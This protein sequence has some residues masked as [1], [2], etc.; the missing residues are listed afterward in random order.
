MNIFSKRETLTQNITYMAI[1]A[2]I[3]II[4]S[5]IAAFL[6]ILSLF[7]MIILPLTSTLVTL[8]CKN[9]YYLIYAVATI[10]LSLVATLYNMGN[11]ILYLVPSILTGFCFGM[12]AKY[13]I[14]SVWYI[15][16]TSIVQC[17][18]T[19]A[20]IPLINFIFSSDIIL[21]FKTALNL[22]ESQ[23]ID[24]IVPTA[25]LF[26]SMIQMLFTYI[27]ISLEMQKFD[28][29]FT[30][31]KIITFADSICSLVAIILMIICSF[32]YIPLSYIFLAVSIYFSAFCF[33]GLIIKHYKV[34]L[35][36]IPVSLLP[37]II[38][39]ALLY[40]LLPNQTG[41][42]LISVFPFFIAL[43]TFINS[44]LKKELS[45]DKLIDK[46]NN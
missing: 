5:V 30:S 29:G 43:I 18:C 38:I 8:Y 11:T 26:L 6:P 46:E 34:A 13:K 20:T 17:A 39:F 14:P 25:V 10:G 35:I 28:K 37:A 36:L 23:N 24:I 32:F 3:N 1:M 21:V 4:F 27:V 16:I 15:F 45:K 19:L 12:M 40:N 42:L 44:L 31:T 22:A 33:V 2:A 9:K 7:L 41:L